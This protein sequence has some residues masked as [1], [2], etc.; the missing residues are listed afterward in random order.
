MQQPLPRAAWSKKMANWDYDTALPNV[1]DK[2]DPAVGVGRLY[3]CDNINHQAYTN[4]SGYCNEKVDEL[5]KKGALEPDNAKRQAIYNE[6]Q[7]LLLE[8]APFVW[9]FDSVY[10]RFHH[11]DLYIP[12][13]G[14]QEFFDEMYWKTAQK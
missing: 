13:Y 12:S 6:A 4:T 14:H 3:R 11:K 8:E 2:V 5:F 9:L 10:W 1:G 7:R